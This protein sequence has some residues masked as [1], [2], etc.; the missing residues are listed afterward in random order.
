MNSK[1]FLLTQLR[2]FGHKFP[3]GVS[4]KYLQEVYEEKLIK[5]INSMTEAVYTTLDTFNNILNKISAPSDSNLLVTIYDNSGYP[6]SYKINDINFKTDNLRLKEYEG[7]VS[8]SDENFD[9]IE[10]NKILLTWIKNPPKSYSERK[11]FFSYLTKTKLSLEDFQVYNKDDDLNKSEV[12][13]PC[14][15]YALEQQQVDSEIIKQI[16]SSMYQTGS[17]IEFIKTTAI[18]FNLHISVNQYIEIQSELSHGGNKTSHYGN[19][20]LPE[21]KLGSIGKHLFAIKQ[22]NI[23]KVALLHPEFANH[24]SFPSIALNGKGTISKTSPTKFLNSFQVISYLYKNRETDL[25]P[26]TQANTP[27]LY[28]NE[29]QNTFSLTKNDCNESL[30]NEIGQVKGKMMFGQPPF[31]IRKGNKIIEEPFN[32]IYFDFETLVRDKEHI[33][34]CIAYKI[35]NE[36]TISL[37][38]FNCA[39]EFLKSI[40]KKSN[41]LLFAHNAGFDVRFLIKHLSGFSKSSNIISS[42]NRVK[43]LTGFFYGRKIIIK[44]T[45]SFLNNKLSELPIM[46]KNSCDKMTLEKESFPHNLIHEDNYLAKWKIDYLNDNL[47][48]EQLDILINNAT[49]INAIDN[50]EFNCIKYAKHYCER[51]VDVLHN[52]FEAFRQMNIDKFKVDVYNFISMPAL[53]YAIQ[54]NKNCYNECY[55]VSGVALSFLR[56]AIV[57]GRCMVKDNGKFHTTHKISDFDGV[58]LYPSAQAR[59]QGYIKGKPKT[60]FNKIPTDADYFVV[61]IKVNT[62]GKKYRFP[63]QSIMMNGSRYFTN[64]LEGEVLYLGKDALEDLVNFQQVTFTIIEGLYWNKGFNPAISS[65]IETL[66]DERLKLKKEGNPL[67]NGIKLLMNSAYGKNA[68]KPIVKQKVLVKGKENIS[69]YLHKNIH[70]MVSKTDISNDLSM[71]EEHKSISNHHNSSHLAIQIL[72]MSKRIMN[73]VMCL[74][75]D[76]GCNIWYQDTDSMHIDTNDIP[77]LAKAFKEKYSRDL[78]GNNLGQFNSDF[79]LVGS[80]GEV[81]ATESYFL[82]K[83]SYL[84]VLSCEDNDA[85]GYHI[86]MKGIPSKLLTK[87]PIETYQK[88]FNGES[89]EFDLTECCPIAINSKTQVVSKRE[90]F[91]RS[92]KF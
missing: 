51:D 79:S 3:T 64:E 17:T 77:K 8:D 16:I 73:E 55:S 6:T 47:D 58:S 38:G 48:K 33:A 22:T 81:F 60:F 87:N 92:I 76:I 20:T 83:K 69:K 27:N 29:Y 25:I 36:P 52:C 35:N 23:T 14:F 10:T 1:S 30:F 84:D 91:I 12:S 82:G 57:G 90:K 7:L 63:L 89:L 19:K 65:T 9:V 53:A 18:K 15:I 11:N 45:M 43:Q 70:K 26:I 86:R 4:T 59:L 49:S 37:Y 31:S 32:I 44:D 40:P 68:L 85:K 28:N 5:Q 56:K 13:T 54:N 39:E 42:G 67:Q 34:Y 61:K 74:A 50:K 71:F 62:V 66:F 24:K 78:I 46:F 21:I 72:D 41:N 80:R 75:E 2:K 88:L